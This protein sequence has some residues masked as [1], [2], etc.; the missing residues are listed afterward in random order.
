MAARV[1]V[2]IDTHAHEP[3]AAARLTGFIDE[4]R[5]DNASS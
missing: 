4:S 5:E 1:L 2:V 3:L